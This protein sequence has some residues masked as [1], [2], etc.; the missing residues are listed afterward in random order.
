MSTSVSK[1]CCASC[2]SEYR[3]RILGPDLKRPWDPGS[4]KVSH[5]WNLKN[6]TGPCWPRLVVLPAVAGPC[7]NR[8]AG[9]SY[10][11]SVPLGVAC[12]MQPYPTKTLVITNQLSFSPYPDCSN[13][14]STSW[15]GRQTW[16]CLLSYFLVGQPTIKFFIFAKT[17]AMLLLSMHVRQEFLLGVSSRENRMKKRDTRDPLVFINRYKLSSSH[18]QIH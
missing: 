1:N 6:Q 13:S 8:D 16:T 14:F 10:L 15:S 17:S 9:V 18:S 4:T 3:H 7:S 12:W 5:K 2:F 11:P